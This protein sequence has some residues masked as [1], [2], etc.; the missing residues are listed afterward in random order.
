M[1]TNILAAALFSTAQ[2]DNEAQQNPVSR[3]RLARDVAEMVNDPY[4][5]TKLILSQHSLDEFCLVL[6]TGTRLVHVTLKFPENYPRTPPRVVVNGRQI[7]L[8]RGEMGCSLI[9]ANEG[10]TLAYTIKNWAIHLLSI[11]DGEA[12]LGLSGDDIERR[13]WP[14][15]HDYSCSLCGLGTRRSGRCEFDYM[16]TDLDAINLDD[17]D[18][19]SLPQRIGFQGPAE[20]KTIRD[21]PDELLKN[22]LAHLEVQDMV[23]FGQAWRRIGDIV[24]A[25]VLIRDRELHCFVTKEHFTDSPLG[26][27]VNDDDFDLESEFD[28]ISLTAFRDLRVRTSAYGFG[29]SDWL[30]LPLSERHWERVKVD[31]FE[32]LGRL[33]ESMYS[34]FRHSP[35]SDALDVLIAFMDDHV[36]K[37]FTNVERRAIDGGA[38]REGARGNTGATGFLQASEK[39][40]ESLFFLFHLLLCLAVEKP[41]YVSKADEMVTSFQDGSTPAHDMPSPGR[42]LMAL[43]ISSVRVD[44]NLMANAIAETVTR[45]TH[46]LL[47][48]HPGLLCMVIRGG[49]SASRL[50]RAVAGSLA[51]Y[52]ALMFADLLARTVRPSTAGVTLQQARDDLFRR[53]GFPSSATTAYLAAETRRILAVELLPEGTR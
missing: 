48:R 37:L 35:D 34:G 41:E 49:G 13:L 11:F 23:R 17:D 16:W 3:R 19:S 44:D 30:P 32:V 25:N 50:H 22:V 4:P 31:A 9:L 42:I 27:G 26:I 52:R 24:E 14:T 1:A 53:R 29:F 21:L 38:S 45:N 39:G 10:H 20:P 40:I 15:W 8:S 6:Y 36:I 12:E 28:L 18:E 5:N 43:L 33:A 7:D 51:P 46:N 47:A 2:P